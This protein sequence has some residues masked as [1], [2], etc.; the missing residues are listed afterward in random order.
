MILKGNNNNNDVEHT[1]FDPILIIY[2]HI[3]DLLEVCADRCRPTP[4]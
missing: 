2:V 4:R 1:A 3:N